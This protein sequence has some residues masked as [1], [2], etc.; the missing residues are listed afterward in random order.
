MMSN[1]NTSLPDSGAIPKS[2]RYSEV[3]PKGL[4]ASANFVD[5]L[6]SNGSTFTDNQIIRIPIQAYSQFL[7]TRHSYLSFKATVNAT[8][9]DVIYFDAG[10]HGC[11]KRVRVLSANNVEL[12]RIDDYPAL[13]ALLGDVVRSYG[14]YSS[15]G[16]LAEGLSSDGAT[17]AKQ[18]HFTINGAKTTSFAIPLHASG[19]LGMLL[20]KYLPLPSMNN[21]VVLE[22]T[23]SPRSYCLLNSNPNAITQFDISDV[24]YV[25][26]LITPP[27]DFLD[28][29]KQVVS[30]SGLVL[31]TVSFR[32]YVTQLAGT[33]G[34]NTIKIVDSLKSCKSYFGMLR[35]TTNLNDAQEYSIT[36][37]GRE[38]LT[39]YIL[40]VNNQPIP[41]SAVSTQGILTA[42]NSSTGNDAP[43]SAYLELLKALSRLGDSQ[44]GFT[45]TGEVY[46]ADDTSAMIG[47]SN[48]QTPKFAIGCD[49][50][51][52]QSEAVLSGTSMYSG[53]T[54]EI[55]V[56]LTGT[57]ANAVQVDSYMMYD[58]E[59]VIDPTGVVSVNY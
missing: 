32:N 15:Q 41:Y 4:K 6:P 30:R 59:V 13:T 22:L 31:S 17:A 1:N 52:F 18:R 26:A 40:R 54:S 43:A 14:N 39:S 57:G 35:R 11:F 25:G 20:R 29:F 49:L 55:Q 33:N 46:T 48:F 38:N 9:N 51:A 19:V 8:N 56:I 5:F 7:D 16:G 58:M 36:A 45:L 42:S 12:E 37:R 3:I 23:V 27:N 53:N 10:G 2:M 34:T 24:K 44:I 21:G 50:E 47:A 28:M